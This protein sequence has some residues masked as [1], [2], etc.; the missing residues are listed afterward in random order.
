LTRRI[1]FTALIALLVVPATASAGDLTLHPRGF[2]DSTYAAWKAQTGEPDTHGSAFQSMYFQKFVPTATFT[3]AIVQIRGVEGAQ[4]SELEG[5]AWDHREDGHC[6]AGAPRW[7]VAYEENGVDGFSQLGCA[8]AE[9]QQ[10]PPA[11]GHG[12]C[13]DTQ[14]QTALDTVPDDAT[15][16]GLFIVFDEGNDAPNVPPPTGDCEQEQFEG[17]FVHLDNITVTLDGVEHTWTGASDNGNN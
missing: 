14:S 3:A 13:R 1:L 6:G 10:Q 15:I 11:S 5:L 16:T 12:W 7:H 17:G 2:G 8:A 4:G 9:H